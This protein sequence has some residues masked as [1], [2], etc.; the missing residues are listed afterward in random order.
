VAVKKPNGA[1][2]LAMRPDDF[3]E[4]FALSKSHVYSLVARGVVR[5]IRIG[6]T[7]RIPTDVV[8]EM[9][10]TLGTVKPDSTDQEQFSE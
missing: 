4:M 5:S 1:K 2:P 7:I 9:L 10:T 6:R 8:D 3:G